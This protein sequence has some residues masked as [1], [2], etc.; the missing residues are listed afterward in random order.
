M[1]LSLLSRT[2]A[3]STRAIG[4]KVFF[5]CE[6]RNQEEKKDNKTKLVVKKKKCGFFFSFL[7]M[8]HSGASL[9]C[10]K[11]T[12][13]IFSLLLLPGIQRELCAY[14]RTAVQHI[15]SLQLSE[16]NILPFLRWTHLP[17]TS[18][19][20]TIDQRLETLIKDTM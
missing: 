7:A 18:K 5:F 16:H 10:S 14:T 11:E 3:A 2:T 4:K 8:T 6:R 20:I 12:T 17:N 13:I 19:F 15:N 1:P 9:S